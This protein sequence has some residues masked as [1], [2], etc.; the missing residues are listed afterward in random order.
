MLPKKLNLFEW[1]PIAPA[2]FVLYRKALT[3]NKFF[4]TSKK[5][6]QDLKEIRRPY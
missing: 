2:E 1:S 5:G 6:G 4:C 3:K